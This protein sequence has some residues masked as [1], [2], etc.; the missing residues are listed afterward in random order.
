LAVGIFE[1]ETPILLGLK[2]DLRNAQGF[3]ALQT[4]RVEKL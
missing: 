1:G 2:K 3:Y 4:V